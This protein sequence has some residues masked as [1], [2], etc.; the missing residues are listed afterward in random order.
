MC[1]RQRR[2]EALLKCVMGV[3][4]EERAAGDG[5]W[6]G[7]YRMSGRHVISRSA[8][9]CCQATAEHVG[10]WFRFGT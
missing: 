5:G 10:V 7:S 1:A 4:R 6:E 2:F 9:S 3:E 8:C